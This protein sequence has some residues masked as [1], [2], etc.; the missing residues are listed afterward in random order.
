MHRTASIVL[1]IFVLTSIVTYHLVVIPMPK[2][3]MKL[4]AISKQ[5][6]RRVTRMYVEANGGSHSLVNRKTVSRSRYLGGLTI[7]DLHRFSR[8]YIC[9]GLGFNAPTWISMGES[10]TTMEL[11]GHG[12]L[13]L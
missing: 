1:A 11:H 10:K 12:P 5:F 7:A 8:L 6:I 2:W 9:D 3:S 4:N 13:Q